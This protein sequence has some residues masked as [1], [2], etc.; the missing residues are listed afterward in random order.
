M[1][2]RS[3]IRNPF[4]VAT[5]QGGYRPAACPNEFAY[6]H[7]LRRLVKR[8]LESGMLRETN[9]ARCPVSMPWWIAATLSDH[10]KAQ[11]LRLWA[12]C[13]TSSP[14]SSRSY[15]E[16][17]TRESAVQ[18]AR[19]ADIPWII[20]SGLAEIGFILESFASSCSILRCSC[21]WGWLVCVMARFSHSGGRRRSPHCKRTIYEASP[22]E[23][24]KNSLP[25]GEKSPYSPLTT[26][27]N[28]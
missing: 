27:Q 3:T 21:S 22:V 8:N 14:L 12:L 7:L 26:G 20:G 1:S 10:Q 16:K 28:V 9:P 18:P 24:S 6:C 25:I 15:V 4:A 23:I 5:L 19:I 2:L 13:S 11:S 17:K